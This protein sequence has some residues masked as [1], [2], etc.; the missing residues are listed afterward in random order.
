MPKNA[1][2]SNSSWHY[3]ETLRD[4]A[5]ANSR[6]KRG[7]TSIINIYKAVE[8]LRDMKSDINLRSSAVICA[9][10][11]GGPKEQSIRNNKIL[12]EIIDAAQKATLDRSH[13]KPMTLKADK[14]QEILNNIEDMQIRSRVSLIISELRQTKIQLNNLQN[15]FKH[16]HAIGVIT[17][18]M[19]L[20]STDDLSNL[21]T[22][23]EEI[24]KKDFNNTFSS[25]EQEDCRKFLVSL[26]KEGL[27]ADD[28]SGEIITK[29]GRTFALPG[30]LSVLRRVSGGHGEK[31]AV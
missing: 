10:N 24:I 18:G 9:R 5:L 13:I 17:N 28:D 14:Y 4:E 21:A 25:Q 3:V 27:I 12:S 29:S 1:T 6:N 19:K 22:K 30:V 8:L 7:Y 31:M 23:I 2:A 26:P 20:A 15:G 16:L 11:W